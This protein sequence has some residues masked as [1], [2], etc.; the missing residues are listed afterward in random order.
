MPGEVDEC[1][2]R[3]ALVDGGISLDVRFDAGGAC[4]CGGRDVACLGA[5]DAGSDGGGKSEGIAYGENPFAHFEFFG[6]THRDDVEVGGV[7]FYECKVGGGI[8]S[9]NG[10]IEVTIVVKGD[11]EA[12]GAV[13]DVV[14]GDDVSVLGYNDARAEAYLPLL[15]LF[16]RSLLSTR[17]LLS[18]GVSEEKVEEWV[19]EEVRAGLHLSLGTWRGVTLDGYDAVDCGLGGPSEVVLR[20]DTRRWG[21]LC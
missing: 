16:A 17:S 14:I 8:R 18:V 19:G 5:H 4:A 10:G 2:A 12:F 1:A 11:F 13:N 15:G 7:N 21:V 9:H 3:I 6:I 20:D